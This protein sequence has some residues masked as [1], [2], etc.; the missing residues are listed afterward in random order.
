MSEPKPPV[1][2]FPV[3]YAV[4]VTEGAIV[5]FAYLALTT[6]PATGEYVSIVAK[7]RAACAEGLRS[8]GIPDADIDEAQVQQVA[9]MNPTA[10]RTQSGAMVSMEPEQ[11]IKRKPVLPRQVADI[12]E[13]DDLI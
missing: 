6:D 8:L 5:H 1:R 13:P 4:R 11:P 9:L 12:L 2:P 3:D 10:I 7:T